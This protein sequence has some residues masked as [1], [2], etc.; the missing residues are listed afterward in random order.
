[1]YAFLRACRLSQPVAPLIAAVRACLPTPAPTL[2][3]VSACSPCFVHV[4]CD[5]VNV[6]IVTVLPRLGIASGSLSFAEL[7]VKLMLNAI[8]TGA[9]VLKGK[10]QRFAVIVMLCCR[11]QDSTGFWLL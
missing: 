5:A 11:D 1:M 8:S 7:S 2:V 6:D 9:H 4:P 10:A 3:S